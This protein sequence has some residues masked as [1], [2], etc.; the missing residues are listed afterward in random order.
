MNPLLYLDQGS[1]QVEGCRSWPSMIWKHPAWRNC[2]RSSVVLYNLKKKGQF[3]WNKVMNMLGRIRKYYYYIMQ[4][5]HQQFWWLGVVFFFC[6]LFLWKPKI[7]AMMCSQSYIEYW[8]KIPNHVTT[9]RKFSLG[10]SWEG[11]YCRYSLFSAP[12][13]CLHIKG[14][15]IKFQYRGYILARSF[16]GA[17]NSDSVI[18]SV[19]PGV[20]SF[21]AFITGDIYFPTNLSGAKKRQFPKEFC[22]SR[23]HLQV[24]YTYFTSFTVFI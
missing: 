4:T 9:Y 12:T 3:Q 1:F 15:I 17:C 13:L 7:L 21:Q 22:K 14:Y 18:A 8:R 24:F 23:K 5:S 11:Y 10:L 6:C 20:A 2:W 19:L 16:Y